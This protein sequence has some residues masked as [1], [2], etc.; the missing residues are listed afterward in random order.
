M[1]E[2]PKRRVGPRLRAAGALA[3]V[4]LSR[5]LTGRGPANRGTPAP[6]APAGGGRSHSSP[7]VAG[8]PQDASRG[9]LILWRSSTW[10][11]R[12]GGAVG[13]FLG[14]P[15]SDERSRL[16]KFRILSPRFI[17]PRPLPPVPGSPA[18]RL[19]SPRGAGRTGGTTGPQ[20]SR[21]RQEDAKA[22]L[23][24]REPV[25]R[26][27]HPTPGSPRTCSLR[28]ALGCYCLDLRDPWTTRRGPSSKSRSCRTL[29]PLRW[30]P[31][32]LGRNRTGPG[33]CRSAESRVSDSDLPPS[34][35]SPKGRP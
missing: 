28:A 1:P 4:A 26:T 2:A 35:S 18:P 13:P 3:S 9:A 12:S 20:S 33:A 14:P 29:L 32:G 22:P 8:P 6:T 24:R 16:L 21:W 10:V 7:E 19:A 27:R 23:L 11:V 5:G 15:E 25:R 30:S 17:N 31:D 34:R